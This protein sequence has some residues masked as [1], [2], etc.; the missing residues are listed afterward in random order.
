MNYTKIPEQNNEYMPPPEMNE[1]VV[2]PLMEQQYVPPPQQTPNNDIKLQP[3]QEPNYAMSSQ[4][5]PQYGQAFES[6]EPS[7]EIPAIMLTQE[8]PNSIVDPKMFKTK[9]LTIRCMFCEIPITTTVTKKCNCL[10]LFLFLCT[11]YIY[12]FVQMCRKK[13]VCV[14]DATHVCPNCGRT[15]GT[16][17]AC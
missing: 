7:N 16:Y 5:Q 10:A 15:V 9:P 6:G 1:N 13:D 17:R 12:I 11:G 3:Q 8:E 4:Q 14:Y 2:F